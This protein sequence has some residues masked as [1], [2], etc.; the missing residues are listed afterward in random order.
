MILPCTD[1]RLKIAGRGAPNSPN[2]IY[3]N[4]RCSLIKEGNGTP[5]YKLQLTESN[6]LL[7]KEL[8]QRPAT[9][10]ERML[11]GPFIYLLL[12]IMA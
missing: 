4:A 7:V 6:Q 8:G 5:Y 11:M 1:L 10:M 3:K 12:A 2:I 9:H